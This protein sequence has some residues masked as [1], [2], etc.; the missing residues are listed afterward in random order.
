MDNYFSPARRSAVTGPRPVLRD[1]NGTDVS[2]ALSS[3]SGVDASANLRHLAHRRA[4]TGVFI[5]KYAAK[6]DWERASFGGT[7]PA[8]A[9]LTR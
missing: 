6:I 7:T 4:A 2:V 9:A 1:A 3:D 8:L 5:W